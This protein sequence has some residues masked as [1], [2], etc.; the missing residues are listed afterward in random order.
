MKNNNVKRDNKV[1]LMNAPNANYA[2]RISIIYLIFGGIWV[3]LSDTLLEFLLPEIEKYR[4]FQTFKAI[5]FI[6]FT[7]VLVY[8]LLRYHIGLWRIE[9]DKKEKAYQ[10]LKS[11]HAEL[12][13]LESELIYQKKLNESIIMEAPTIIMTWDDTGKILSINPFG[14]KVT[15]YKQE[16]LFILGWDALVPD[17]RYLMARDTYFE[18][19]SKDGMLN[20]D[21]PITTKDGKRIDILWSSKI[22]YPQAGEGG[23]IYVSIGTDIEERKKYE[24]Q[25][26]NLAYYDSLT[27]LPNRFK[28]ER[29][30]TKYI[31]KKNKGF[32]IAYMDIDNFKN[33]ND[34]IGHQAGDIFLKYFAETLVEQVEKNA[35]V[36]RLGGDEFAVLYD[37][38]S[39]TEI[40]DKVE[41]LLAHTN[42]IWSYNNRFFYISISV[43][44]VMYPE[45]G[46]SS[47]E[48]LKNADIAMYASKREGRN[49]IIFYQDDLLEENTRFADMANYLQEGI[50]QDQ[51]YLVYQPQY[52]LSDRSLIG[53]EALLRWEHPTEGF[54]SP[55]EF[56]PT[57][58]RTGQIYRLEKMVISKAL[59]QKKTW[60]QQ[61]F[62][63]I[64]MSINLSTRTLTS[65][66]NFSEWEQILLDYKVDYSKIIIEITETADIM[67]VDSV[68]QRLNRLK[69][70]GIRIA[71]DDFGT[72]YSSLNYLKKLPIDI[73]KL[74]RSFIH[75]I[76]DDGV[77]TLLIKN[78][79]TMAKDLGY[80]VIAEGIET[81]EQ[82]Q[83]LV[84]YN[85]GG[86]QGFLL[87][88]PLSEDNVSLLLEK[89]S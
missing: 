25:I 65:E 66:I 44:I 30:I 82:M 69:E 54:I 77:D 3:F 7:T 13:T 78:I 49:R 43:G 17:D 33:I 24:E 79:L 89:I 16:E 74:D 83:I 32:M 36:A 35:F 80:E 71:L 73:I 75:A 48:L 87:S 64:S 85:C 42:R 67:E 37:C 39:R 21:G 45:H 8:V 56:I 11:T 61:G 15:G 76:T 53:M 1:K 26:K 63:D 40:L 10:E 2:L 18:I 58:E 60:E 86:G 23:N 57:A 55:A 81:N 12:V 22:L 34:S 14:E 62:T 51:F 52:R 88:K 6:L 72:G 84:N 41:N 19:K 70:R 29:E 38:N 4:Y 59:E 31:K 5:I 46:D 9:Y 68:I 28:F 20:Y 27:K 47:L 50:D